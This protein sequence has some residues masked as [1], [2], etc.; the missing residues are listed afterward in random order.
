VNYGELIRECWISARDDN[1]AGSSVEPQSAT[2]IEFLTM[3]EFASAR[4]TAIAVHLP[5]RREVA[6]QHSMRKV[7]SGTISDGLD[8]RIAVAESGHGAVGRSDSSR[9]TETMRLSP[10]PAMRPASPSRFN[11]PG[12][13]GLH[14]VS[15]QARRGR[16]RE[17]SKRSPDGAWQLG[18]PNQDGERG[19][20]ERSR[21]HRQY[22]R[23]NTGQ[24]TK[25]GINEGRLPSPR[26]GFR[27]PKPGAGQPELPFSFESFIVGPCNALAREATLALARRRQQ[28]LNQLYLAGGSGMGK[29]HLARAA[30]A[31]ARLH[32]YRYDD[33][34]R[35]GSAQFGEAARPP[36]PSARREQAPRVIYTSAFQFTSEFV[37]ARRRGVPD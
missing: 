11:P 36:S 12:A 19:G 21:D 22:T 17:S 29:T 27:E 32:T 30:A 3:K 26:R 14:A 13:S 24:D 5:E 7:G 15:E 31:E 6:L 37:W 18:D 9:S 8:A 16:S 10:S 2:T 20:R 35:S 28:S 1:K 25:E 4:G 33:V 23:Q 34:T